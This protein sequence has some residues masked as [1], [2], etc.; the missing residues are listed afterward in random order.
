MEVS[1]FFTEIDGKALVKQRDAILNIVMSPEKHK[2]SDMQ[3]RHIDAVINVLDT[4]LDIKDDILN[5]VDQAYLDRGYP[6]I[7]E[8]TEVNFKYLTEL[9]Y[10]FAPLKICNALTTKVY[11]EDSLDDKIR[12]VRIYNNNEFVGYSRVYLEEGKNNREYVL[13][14]MTVLY[15]DLLKKKKN[16]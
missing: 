5:A 8:G 1:S 13:I 6:I 3:V 2:L 11:S 4:I 7:D 9:T 15:L 16:K 10:S 12:W 14:N